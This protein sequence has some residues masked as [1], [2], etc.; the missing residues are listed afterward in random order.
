MLKSQT[1]ANLGQGIKCVALL[2]AS[3]SLLAGCGD[4]GTIGGTSVADGTRP[5][6][7]SNSALLPKLDARFDAKNGQ[8]AIEDDSAETAVSPNQVPFKGL[9]GIPKEVLTQVIRDRDHNIAEPEGAR[10]TTLKSGTPWVRGFPDGTAYN[11]Y[12]IGNTATDICWPYA[13]GGKIRTPVLP[14]M[15]V[16]DWGDGTNN[17]RVY[18]DAQGWANVRCVPRTIFWNLPYQLQ[19]NYTY[20]WNQCGSYSGNSGHTGNVADMLGGLGYDYAEGADKFGITQSSST[21]VQNTLQIGQQFSTCSGVGY[22]NGVQ[23][24]NNQPVVFS[25]PDGIG[26]A[27][28]AGEW[29]YTTQSASIVTI[30]LS[31]NATLVTEADNE[32]YLSYFGGSLS[33]NQDY[34]AVFPSGGNWWLQMQALNGGV[35]A[36]VRCIPHSQ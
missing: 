33:S 25:G 15:F 18:K 12:V 19:Y 34:V 28:A 23:F 4:E 24:F 14:T 21:S 30:A 31:H 9:E 27:N 5:A 7:A 26:W 6:V 32:C 29:N 20:L 2:A 17:I 22:Y 36:K 10:T 35:R 16:G 8:P 1:R 3:S 13:I 11:T